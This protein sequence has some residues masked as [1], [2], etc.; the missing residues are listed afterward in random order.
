MTAILRSPLRAVAMPRW[1]EAVILAIAGVA[2]W[3]VYSWRVTSNPPGFYLDEASIAY[4]AWS[5]AQTGADEH[6]VAWPVFFQTWY[7]SAA[8]N[9]VFVYLLAAVFKLTGPSIEVARLVSV[10]LGFLAALV[11]GF[12]IWRATRSRGAALI[13][14]GLALATPWLFEPSRLVF[15]VSLFPLVLGLLLLAVRPNDGHGDWTPRR[16]VAIA[17]L[18]G[19]VTYT[20]TV[21]RLLGPMLAAGLLLFLPGVRPRTL[22]AT[23]VLYG[24]TLVP[25]LAFNAAQPGVLTARADLL[26]Y[27]KPGVPLPDIVAK[28]ASQA[29]ANVD[30]GRMLLGGDPNIR[31]HVPEIGTFLFAALV[32]ALIGLDRIAHGAWRDGWRRFLVYGLVVSVVPASLTLDEF[33][34]LR[35]IAVPVFLLVFAGLGAGWLASAAGWQRTALI[36]IV[37]VGVVQAT[38]FEVQFQRFGPG[39]GAAMDASFPPVFEAALAAKSTPIYLSDRGELPGYIE[40]YWYGALRGL[41][42]TSFVRLAEGDLPPA[43]AIV[44]GTNKNCGACDV[45]R[46]SGDYIAY[47]AAGGTMGPVGGANLIANGDFE[48]IAG[49]TI[50]ASGTPIYGWQ[51]FGNAT[52][53]NGGAAST[54]AHLVLQHGP[55][56]AVTEQASSAV[57]PVSPGSTVRFSAA[58]SRGDTSGKPRITVALVEMDSNRQYVTWHPISTTVGASGWQ[59]VAEE[60]I[61]LAPNTAYV[62]V[63]CY[64]EQGAPGDEG[65]IDDVAVTLVR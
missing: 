40:A 30:L 63:S 9:P 10:G 56:G 55:N 27:I 44:L 8:I 35:L 57:S 65:H 38:W 54:V 23:W 21:G 51:T 61:Q 43:G 5:I 53:A 32:L 13:T 46:Q 49:S 50:G 15:E 17:V 14:A 34:T 7:P 1:A 48:Q 37:A 11:I 47:R 19:L 42:R 33:H 24:V 2:A 6:G 45:L 18:L 60:R 64:L 20:Y 59:Q 12:V 3:L 58:I 22:A 41:D 26:G 39:R 25:A 4:N 62:S 28:F 31:H 36:G 16:V 29:L 52:L